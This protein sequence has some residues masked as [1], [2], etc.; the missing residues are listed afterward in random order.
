MTTP[1][2]KVYE[3]E[4]GEWRW[5][6]VSPNGKIIADSGEG[7]LDVKNCLHG[8]QI[9]KACA[10]NAQVDGLDTA[11]RQMIAEALVRRSRKSLL[12]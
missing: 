11:R 3:D 8:I 12:G 10:A 5:R 4:R 6:L 9:I 7:Y 2:F 1:R